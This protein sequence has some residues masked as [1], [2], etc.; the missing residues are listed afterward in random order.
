MTGL[1]PIDLTGSPSH[2]RPNVADPIPNT[3]SRARDSLANERTFLAWVRTGLGFV[4][5]GVVV[6]RL[7][8]ENV[9][10]LVAGLAFVLAGATLVGYALWRYR[11][12]EGLLDT[13]QFA[14]ARNGPVVLVTLCAAL[15]LAAIVLLVW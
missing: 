4:G 1:D 5:L 6:E 9:R 3:D 10:G 14:S 15:S 2:H 7:G 13:R 12:L 11:R 8:S